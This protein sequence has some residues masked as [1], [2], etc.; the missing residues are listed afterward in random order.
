MPLE[1]AKHIILSQPHESS[2]RLKQSNPETIQDGLRVYDH[3]WVMDGFGASFLAM[4]I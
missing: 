1:S 4:A 2:W 3:K